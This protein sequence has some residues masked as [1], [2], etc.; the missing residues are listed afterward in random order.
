MN[1]GNKVFRA[2]NPDPWLGGAVH[3]HRIVPF[4]K[5]T[6]SRPLGLALTGAYGVFLVRG[7]D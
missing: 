3:V 1:R 6:V 5:D 7:L 2:R 4:W